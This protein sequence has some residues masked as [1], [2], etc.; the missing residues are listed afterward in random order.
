MIRIGT[1]HSEGGWD[2]SHTPKMVNT[3]TMKPLTRD[4]PTTTHKPA[5]NKA[6]RRS[7]R[8]SGFANL[9]NALLFP[10]SSKGSGKEYASLMRAFEQALQGA[11]PYTGCFTGFLAN[12]FRA[13]SAQGCHN[14]C[15]TWHMFSARA[16]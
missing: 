6:R 3:R 1:Q 8:Q 5:S 10:L 12:R 11:S 13:F 2:P 9:G 14:L 7:E 4:W 16:A 15:Q